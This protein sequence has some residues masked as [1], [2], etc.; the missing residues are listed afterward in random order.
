MLTTPRILASNEDLSVNYL[1]D[2]PDG[3]RFEARFVHR[4]GSDYFI[5]YVSAFNGC[6]QA[7]RMCHLTSNGETSMVAA[8]PEQIINQID[9]AVVHAA[10]HFPHLRKMHINFMARGE[11]LLN[12]LLFNPTEWRRFV[13]RVHKRYS[14]L[15]E[16]TERISTIMPKEL[17][18]TNLNYLGFSSSTIVYYSLYSVSKH[19]RKR[20]LPKAMDP[21][22][23]LDILHRL[24]MGNPVGKVRFHWALIDEE[25]DMS[26]SAAAIQGLLAEYPQF[27]PSTGGKVRL[28]LVRYNPPN[29]KSKESENYHEYAQ[30]FANCGFDV[31]VIPRV[32]FDV[33]ASCGMFMTGLDDGVPNHTDH[34]KRGFQPK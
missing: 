1:H 14:H 11:P 10:N 27:W 22:Q 32:G 8:T 31:K 16:V 3:G 19:F 29:D 2:T 9:D 30:K 25:N 12:T 24:Q 18:D 20:W 17:A 7:C 23:A 34:T 4:P 13:E 6:D 26:L 15:T 21:G 5:A 33:A 28:N